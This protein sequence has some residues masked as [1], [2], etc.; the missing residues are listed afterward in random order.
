VFLIVY[1]ITDTTVT[2]YNV[3]KLNGKLET[4]K[5][6]VLEIKQSLTNVLE[7]D[8][9]DELKGKLTN[10]I[11]NLGVKLPN[12]MNIKETEFVEDIKAYLEQKKEPTDLKLYLEDKYKKLYESL[13]K[14]RKVSFKKNAIQDRILRA[15]PHIKSVEFD[16]YLNQLKSILTNRK[17]K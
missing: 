12:L 13:E 4:I 7:S 10:S 3:I 15:Y 1:L 2:V 17:S 9:T 8:I 14:Y 6:S 16:E 5:L 11:N